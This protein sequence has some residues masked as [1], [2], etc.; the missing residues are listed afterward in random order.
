MTWLYNIYEEKQSKKIDKYSYT[1][2]NLIR[3]YLNSNSELSKSKKP[4]LWIYIPYE[5]NSRNWLSFG[6]RSSLELNQPYLYLTVKSIIEKCEDSFT[7]C[8]V[9]NNSFHKLIPNWDINMS[10]ISDPILSNMVQFGLC[11][12]LHYYGGMIVPISFLCFRDLIDLYNSGIGQNKDKMFVCEG[13]N[14]NITS[15]SWTE[16]EPN[17]YFTPDIHFMGCPKENDT[18]LSLINYMEEIISND[19]TA[20]S[21]FLGQFNRWCINKIKE[22]KITLI[23]GTMVGIKTRNDNP[24]LID[25]LLN[26]GYISYKDNM[27][28]INIP[29]NEIINRRNYEWFARLSPQQVLESDTIIGKYILIANAPGN[30]LDYT[31]KVNK[32]FSRKNNGWLQFWKIPSDA[33]MWGLKPIN[34]GGFVPKESF[35]RI[36]SNSNN[37][38]NENN[39]QTSGPKFWDVPSGA[40]VWGLKPLY[41]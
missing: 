31:K 33:P 30:N 1:D 10:T 28:G 17:Q 7:I 18:I 29:S 27:Y 32:E 4:I 11:K 25:N 21:V 20:E 13:I 35:S 36:N 9:D 23:D 12:L 15:M 39:T 34:L 2:Y 16:S 37:I 6:S 3:K 14:R 22:E 24:V 8:L 5:Y 40:P 38:D 26:K 19:F 41:F